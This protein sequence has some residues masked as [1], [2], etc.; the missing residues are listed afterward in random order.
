MEITKHFKMI[1]LTVVGITILSIIG[2]ATLAFCGDATDPTK[3]PVMQQNLYS[4]C[5][6]GWQ[7][8]IGAIFGLLG[9]NATA[10]SGG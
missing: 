5:S 8:G 2:V 7:S 10:N 1:F 4:M 3:I 9:G 6:F